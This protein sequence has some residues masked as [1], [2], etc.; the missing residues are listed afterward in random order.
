MPRKAGVS[1]AQLEKVLAARK[2][3]LARLRK[4]R[5]K[6]E[7]GLEGLDER[8]AALVGKPTRVRRRR[9]AKVARVKKVV[10][11][12]KAGRKPGG[13]GTLRDTVYKVLRKA[14]G[15]MKVKEITDAAIKS[16]YQTKSKNLAASVIPI[17]YKD[18]A[19]KKVSRGQFAL[20]P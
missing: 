4:K 9:R 11:R 10:G 3:A 18:P 1:I 6:L 12:R 17:V 5:G 20:K 2:K 16:G 19:I 7:K 14:E 13:K 15:P 8:I